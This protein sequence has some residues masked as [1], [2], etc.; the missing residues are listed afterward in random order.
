MYMY[1][2]QVLYMQLQIVHVWN[3]SLESVETRQQGEFSVQVQ[4]SS[5]VSA[6]GEKMK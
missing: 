4:Q 6:T 2:G 5:A 3:C 1:M